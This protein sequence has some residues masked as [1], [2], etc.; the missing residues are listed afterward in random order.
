ML[1]TIPDP[2]RVLKEMRALEA[3]H[4]ARTVKIRNPGGRSYRAMGRGRMLTKSGDRV[5]KG[6]RFQTGFSVMA[7][8]APKPVRLREVRRAQNRGAS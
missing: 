6:Q 7:Q 1:E 4:R 3:K 5:V 8:A 2:H